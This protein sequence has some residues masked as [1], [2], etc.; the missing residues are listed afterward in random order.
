MKSVAVVL[1]L[2]C[3]S[4]AF[5]EDFLLIV[6]SGSD[7]VIKC[8]SATGGFL[9]TLCTMPVV[10]SAATPKEALQVGSEIWVSD[11]L[12][13]NVVRFDANGVY[14]GV[15][16]G[17]AQGLDN[18]RGFEVAGGKIW[19]TCGSGTYA[20]QVAVFDQSTHEFLFSVNVTGSPFDCRLFNGEILVSN[21]ATH[22]IDRISL[23]GVILGKFVDSTG[24]DQPLD[25]PQQITPSGGDVLVAEF[26]NP[27][28]IFRFSSEGVLLEAIDTAPQ[29]GVRGV[30]RLTNG[31]YLFTNGS[32]VYTYAP[33]E[34][35]L[36]LIG[37]SCQYINR[38]L[39]PTCPADFDGDGFVTGA[40]FDAFVQAFEAGDSAADF[41]GDG[42]I[43]G[44]DF[45]EYVQAFE[46]GC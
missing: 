36:P 45:D 11:Q 25:F 13:D 22:D 12:Q 27:A 28:E 33:G 40:D 16:V 46:S 19:V 1:T 8:D 39:I 5:A 35:T 18:V 41:D 2:V 3:G 6:D 10:G 21:S 42:F 17:P 31:R 30:Y 43:T 29:A 24:A 15:V 4:V 23:G 38:Y 20:G 34:G 26:S 37:G 7:T 44:I 32:G 9:S 14:L